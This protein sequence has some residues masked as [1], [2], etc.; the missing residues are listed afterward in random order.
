ML[1]A[2]RTEILDCWDYCGASAMARIFVSHSGR[3]RDATRS[4][5]A[6]LEGLGWSVWWDKSPQSGYALSDVRA[7]E[8]AN[9][10][11]VI[12]IWSKSSITAPYVLSD[13]IAARDANKLM[14]VTNSDEP[15]KQIPIRHRDEPLLDAFDLLQISLAVSSFMRRGWRGPDTAIF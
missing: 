12:V 2:V 11:L 6:F 10:E 8:F 13:A 4:L 1:A 14:Q 7:A 3:D 9:A 5:V 15:P